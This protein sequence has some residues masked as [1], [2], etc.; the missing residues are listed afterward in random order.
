MGFQDNVNVDV[1]GAAHIAPCT[2][3]TVVLKQNI[4]KQNLNVLTQAMLDEYGT[5]TKFV[6][7]WDY[8]LKTDITIPANCILEFDGGSIIGNG[9]NKDT[10][11]GNN[12]LIVTN[13]IKIF[14]N[15][16]LNGTFKNKYF[17][18][19]W[20]GSITQGNS[21]SGIA[22]QNLNTIQ[23]AIDNAVRTSVLNV[24][25]GGYNNLSN[26]L[27]K[28]VYI[29]GTIIIPSMCSFGAIS[30][31]KTQCDD[32]NVNYTICQISNAPIIRIGGSNLSPAWCSTWSYRISIHDIGLLSTIT[33]NKDSLVYGIT[34]DGVGDDISWCTFDR[35][36]IGGCRFGIYFH[37]SVGDSTGGSH[38]IFRQVYARDNI[39]GIHLK[40]EQGHA[41][42][43]NYNI[44]DKCVLSFNYN[45]GLRIHEFGQQF[46]SN[47][48]EDCI[49]EQNGTN[50]NSEEYKTFGCSGICCYTK[51]EAV[52]IVKNCYFEQNYASKRTAD[53]EPE[54]G[55]SWFD[56]SAYGETSA[57]GMTQNVQPS[58]VSEL[59]G[60]IVAQF[61]TI[62]VSG[63]AIQGSHVY[64]QSW[65]DA[66]FYIHDNT[67]G[68]NVINSKTKDCLVYYT[69]FSGSSAFGQIRRLTILERNIPSS[70]KMPYS[71]KNVD[72]IATNIFGI[73]TIN[74]AK[75]NVFE[76]E[77]IENG[78][79]QECAT[80]YLDVNNSVA[81]Y[82]TS[83]TNP[84]VASVAPSVGTQIDT[85]NVI[86]LKWVLVTS[87][88]LPSTYGNII[89]YNDVIFEGLRLDNTIT[90]KIWDSAKNKYA[91]KLIFNHLTVDQDNRSNILV[92]GNTYVEFNN[93]IIKVTKDS[94]INF[95]SGVS[96]IVFNNCTFINES[97][98]TYFFIEN[99]GNSVKLTTKNC[100]IPANV[101]VA[102]NPI[103][104][105]TAERNAIA[106]YR[107]VE[108]QEYYD[109]DLHKPL[110]YNGTA[111]VDATGTEV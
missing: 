42:W 71:F 49:F 80:L 82:K 103:K 1:R 23:S 67:F 97:A 66:D 92:R 58:T 41:P 91:G 16:I 47:I 52:L 24:I 59:E 88:R 110:Y 5:N 46:D 15:I 10:I 108:G 21:D 56:N 26:L 63:C 11:T 18:V 96:E 19:E 93:C 76:E 32:P 64:F 61:T 22:T 6:I 83:A 102:V 34:N 13:T 105:T 33:P 31:S 36:Y 99:Y 90:A 98:N 69:T 77:H 25:I 17:E 84:G 62:D 44:F 3:K 94:F 29:N 51:K 109:T 39:I 55:E 14:E 81:N 85:S 38:N 107:L 86:T 87:S 30:R 8:V 50:Y 101:V 65:Y 106:S 9:D 57:H 73:I 78:K 12:T 27:G 95:I 2:Y 60:A 45:V 100:T 68:S 111:W 70:I 4:T 54:T 53:A 7:K 75:N 104:G 74:I 72:S 89:S 43:F 40:G 28:R 48:I 35:V 37:F 79:F 20:F